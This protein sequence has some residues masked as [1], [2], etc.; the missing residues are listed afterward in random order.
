M[1]TKPKARKAPAA[2]VRS[3]A[4]VAPKPI[5]NTITAEPDDPIFELIKFANAA[6]DTFLLFDPSK[7]ENT[8]IA[9]KLAEAMYRANELLY[10][11][12]PQTR[13]GTLAYAEWCLRHHGCRNSLLAAIKR[14]FAA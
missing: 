4:L 9:M 11:A 5:A 8:P 2:K 14:E 3:K 7:P 13:A 10:I 6:R 12:V 1:T